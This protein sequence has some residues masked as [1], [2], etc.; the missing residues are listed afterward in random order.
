MINLNE[1]PFGETDAIL[2]APISAEYENLNDYSAT[3]KLTWKNTS[4]LLTGDVEKTSENEMINSSQDLDIDLLLV[5][6]HG[7]NSSST[8]EF[9]GKTTPNYAVISSGKDNSYGHPHKEVMERLSN[10][11]IKTYNTAEVGTVIASLG[12]DEIDISTTGKKEL[13]YETNKKVESN[14]KVVHNKETSNNQNTNNV[15]DSVIEKLE[16]VASID[17]PNPKQNSD[18]VLTAKVTSNGK[19]VEGATVKILNH[20]KSTTTPYEGITDKDGLAQITY[21]IG[22]SSIGFEVKVDVT[23]IK[24]NLEAKTQTSFTPQ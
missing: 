2:V 22:R 20:F 11:N 9:L 7:S 23:V 18:V 8:D 16:V 4:V 1:I 12:G 5:P 15:E 17:N 3:V 10:R 21:G 24:D 13:P 6:H 19:P 14:T